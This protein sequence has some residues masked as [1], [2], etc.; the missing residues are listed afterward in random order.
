VVDARDG[1]VVYAR[2]PDEAL[3]PASNVKI[4]TAI[5]A[6]SA[7][8]PA[9][10]FAT[11]V[12]ADREIPADGAVE[13][14]YIRAAGDPAL[15]SEEL[16]RLAAD[17]RRRGLRSVKGGIVVDASLFDE[18]RWHP[19]W[20]SVSSRA[21]NAPIGAF[22]ANFGAFA[23]RVAPGRASGDALQIT[24]DPP[25][26]SLR[27]VNR[28]RTLSPRSRVGLRVDRRAGAG[29]DDVL[30][31]GGLPAGADPRTT[32]RSV[33]DPVGY[34]V[35]VLR[36]QLEANGIRVGDA[37]GS[38]AIPDSAVSLVSFE[39]K[40]LADVVRLF[41]KYS[42]N[43]IGEGLVKSLAARAGS[44]P[45]GWTQGIAAIRVELDSIGI[46]L[47]DTVQIDG[48]G[49]SYA[50]RVA[51]RTFVAALRVADASFR[52]GPEF[53]AS[54]PIAGA[55]GTLAERG[56]D[57]AYGVRAKTGSL[58]RVTSLSGYANRPD[59]RRVVFS[60]LVNGFKRGT[61][62]A[63]QGVDDFLEV[64]VHGSAVDAAR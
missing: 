5:A 1:S 58:T 53:V 29:A 54:L 44:R 32:Y 12:L 51:P 17:L 14:L 42:N 45:A 31:S 13:T 52:F 15:T 41:M 25:V 47:G 59:R 10:R 24:L 50:N 62:D 27:L 2:N 6:L 56:E 3:V 4:L 33:S 55:D 43:V 64:L 48:S 35:G 21:Y 19:S 28:A 23:V 22:T 18:Q 40:S 57:A 16:W 38:G 39:G 60:L 46:D 20:G 8:G 37:V 34:A 30:I 26:A 63:W 11:E 49:L 36:M 9:Y 7:F 61:A